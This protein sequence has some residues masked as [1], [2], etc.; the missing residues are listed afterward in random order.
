MAISELGAL[1]ELFASIGVLITLIFL[2]FQIRQNTITMRRANL[3]QATESNARALC[4][5]LDEGVSE[6]FIRGLNSLDSLSEV[7]RYRFDN[8]FFQWISSCEQAFIDKRDDT[9]SADSFVVY[10]NAIVGYLLTPGGKQW[11]EE[12]QAWFSPPF[13][14]DVNRLCANPSTEAGAAG[15]NISAINT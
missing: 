14:D 9:F 12:S 6:L 1:G 13:R 7:E 5:L 15:P 8:A 4:A 2:V 10:E 3:R 11:W